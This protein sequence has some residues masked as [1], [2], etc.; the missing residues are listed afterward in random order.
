[1]YKFYAMRN[2]LYLHCTLCRVRKPGFPVMTFA[3][4]IQFG[5]TRALFLSEFFCAAFFQKVF[6]ALSQGPYFLVLFHACSF[7]VLSEKA[8]PR[9]VAP[10]FA[11][12]PDRQLHPSEAQGAAL[13]ADV[14]FLGK[15]AQAGKI[16][17]VIKP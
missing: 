8:Q 12:L 16:V 5:F 2:D 13:Q 9:V 14:P 11:V 6:H 7:S 17:R 4:F 3:N 1:M 15:A 10:F